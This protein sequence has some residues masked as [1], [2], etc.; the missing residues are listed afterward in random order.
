MHTSSSF[1]FFYAFNATLVRYYF[2]HF[3]FIVWL[4]N[5]SVTSFAFIW[6]KCDKTRNTFSLLA[7]FISILLCVRMELKYCKKKK[8]LYH[9]DECFKQSLFTFATFK[10]DDGKNSIE[11]KMNS[12]LTMK[13]QSNG[14]LLHKST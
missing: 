14:F 11:L 5:F 1:R 8:C 7:F 13:I 6:P 3:R 12:E 2:T 9:L 4:D 10:C